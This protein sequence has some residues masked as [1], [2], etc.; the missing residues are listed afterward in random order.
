MTKSA[1]D[2]LAPPTSEEAQAIVE[3]ANAELEAT[4][5]IVELLAP[6]APEHQRR[7]LSAVCELHGLPNPYT[8]GLRGG[9]GDG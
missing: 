8:R 5:T 9:Q 2:L 6:L 7:V 3:R 1:S 4:R